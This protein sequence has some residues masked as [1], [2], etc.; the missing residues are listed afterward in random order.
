MKSEKFG[1]MPIQTSNY[2]KKNKK[3]GLKRENFD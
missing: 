2:A 1:D 3:E